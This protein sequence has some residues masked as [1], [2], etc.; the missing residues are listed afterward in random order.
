[1]LSILLLLFCVRQL[2]LALCQGPI[3]NPM[4]AVHLHP[5][6]TN[7]YPV[8][9]SKISISYF[10]DSCETMG[11]TYTIK[12]FVVTDYG[13]SWD[14]D[15]YRTFP[16]TSDLAS[17]HAL[18]DTSS[19][20]FSVTTPNHRLA[21]EGVSSDLHFWTAYWQ[22][23]TAECPTCYHYWKTPVP[24]ILGEP[25]STPAST[26]SAPYT[27]SSALDTSS[28]S[29]TQS[30]EMHTPEPTA[31][32]QDKKPNESSGS[33]GISTSTKIG[34]GVGVSTGGVAISL[35]IGLACIRSHKKNKSSIP[36][37]DSER[38][39]NGSDET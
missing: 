38:P 14:C 25:I 8:P 6:D 18:C 4:T 2:A 19:I 10:D 31:T 23:S 36:E 29:P 11:N 13:S 20:E 26:S 15:D 21:G 9:A 24:L 28:P 22:I 1:M 17:T 5:P 27:T 16:L 34:V 33:T 37:G 39:P 3:S 12:L 35:I 30:T 32:K 7:R